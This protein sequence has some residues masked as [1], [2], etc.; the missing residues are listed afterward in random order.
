MHLYISSMMMIALLISLFCLLLYK[1]CEKDRIRV[2]RIRGK[3]PQ[4]SELRLDML[5]VWALLMIRIF[6]EILREFPF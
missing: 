4:L 3:D 2:A 1:L 6:R 5:L